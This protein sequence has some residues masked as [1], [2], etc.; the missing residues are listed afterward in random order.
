MASTL[1]RMEFGKSCEERFNGFL[2]DVLRARDDLSWIDQVAYQM[3]STK[4]FRA[5]PNLEEKLGSMFFNSEQ[6]VW[7]P[8]KYTNA[9]IPKR[10]RRHS[11]QTEE[12][13]ASGNVASRARGENVLANK[14]NSN[15]PKR[16]YNAGSLLQRNFSSAMK[17]AQKIRTKN[18]TAATAD[19]LEKILQLINVFPVEDDRDAL[20]ALAFG[21]D[22]A[23]NHFQSGLSRHQTA[24]PSSSNESFRENHS[25][26]RRSLK[27][28]AP[29]ADAVANINLD[30]SRSEDTRA[31][32]GDLA[33][34]IVDAIFNKVRLKARQGFN[35]PIS[36]FY[37]LSMNSKLVDDPKRGTTNLVPRLERLQSITDEN[38]IF[39]KKIMAF[40]QQ[41]ITEEAAKK[42][43]ATLK[44]ELYDFLEWLIDNDLDNDENVNLLGE[45]VNS[46]IENKPTK[47]NSIVNLGEW[48]EKAQSL[49][50]LLNEYD[51][52]SKKQKIKVQAIYEYLASR[53]EF[54]EAYIKA[55]EAHEISVDQLL[56]IRID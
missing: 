47:N 1:S 16:E 29:D 19:P 11:K 38:Q 13:L 27:S 33:R 34:E 14:K 45:N 36:Q 46:I 26:M 41:L 10:Y 44:P 15:S 43:C 20:G 42:S 32:S 18:G 52:L 3:H 25:G 6:R 55:F 37:T 35:V 21:D 12:S 51:G 31:A 40:V 49:K 24:G 23:Q 28:S 2:R 39:P 9:I 7:T 22:A 30:L 4:L 5:K 54:V 50:H 48:Y 8:Q 53:F 17:S 56:R